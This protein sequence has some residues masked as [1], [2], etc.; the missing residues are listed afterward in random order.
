MIISVVNIVFASFFFSD[1]NGYILLQARRNRGDQ[2]GHGRPT[3]L[4]KKKKRKK[5]RKKR[6]KKKKKRKEKKKKK[7]KEKKEENV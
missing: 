7:K 4:Q 3:F 2:G 1:T 6:R 5:E